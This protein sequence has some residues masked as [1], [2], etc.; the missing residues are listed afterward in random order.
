MTEIMILAAIHDAQT[1]H[2]SG[3]FTAQRKV[4]AKRATTVINKSQRHQAWAMRCNLAHPSASHQGQQRSSKH[5]SM[6]PVGCSFEL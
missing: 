3:Q 5:E 2:P 6:D 4:P 1:I